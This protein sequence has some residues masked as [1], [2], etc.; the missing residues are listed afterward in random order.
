MDGDPTEKFDLSIYNK[1][2]TKITRKWFDASSCGF[3]II[4]KKNSR[5][6]VVE[7]VLEMKDWVKKLRLI[8]R[9]RI[10]ICVKITTVSNGFKIKDITAA[11]KYVGKNA[12]DKNNRYSIKALKLESDNGTPFKKIPLAIINDIFQNASLRYDAH[13]ISEHGLMVE[14][15]MGY[16]ER[17]PIWNIHNKGLHITLSRKRV[18]HY[19][20][21]HIDGVG[22]DDDNENWENGTFYSADGILHIPDG[23]ISF[24]S[25]YLQY[26]R[27]IPLPSCE[28]SVTPF[29]HIKVNNNSSFNC[30]LSLKGKKGTAITQFVNKMNQMYYPTKFYLVKYYNI[31]NNKSSITWQIE[32]EVES[33]EHYVTAA[34]I[35]CEH[36]IN[37]KGVD[38]EEKMHMHQLKCPM[39]KSM[40]IGYTYNED[41]LKHLKEYEHFRNEYEEK[42]ECKYNEKCRS[43][44]RLENGENRLDDRCHI[45]LYRH[46]PRAR[47]ITLSEDTN[48]FVINRNNDE[49]YALYR[50]SFVDNIGLNGKD[51]YLKQLIVEVVKNGFKSDLCLTN[52][53]TESNIY[54]II[55]IVDHKMYSK[56]HVLMGCPLNRAEML[57]LILYTGCDCNYDLC[58]SQRKGN[59]KKWK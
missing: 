38:N 58:K 17:R 50:P 24:N 8:S 1:F 49:N 7:S 15:K 25:D 51:G 32:L 9:K 20:R 13:D 43:Y 26:I 54:S 59:Y 21:E 40:K 16:L 22:P 34:H 18:S 35:T 2:D 5:I 44:V 4:S 11:V 31:S 33:Y 56:R 29:V 27:Y 3:T 39:Y 52:D 57:S 36:M 10:K 14:I 46:P 23:N 48:P 28:V 41:N 12:N 55:D 53:D 42:P 37:F 45:K 19:D 30:E 47:Q 6:F